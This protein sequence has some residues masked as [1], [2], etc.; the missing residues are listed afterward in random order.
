[1]ISTHDAV[2]YRALPVVC[3]S[4]CAGGAEH[5]RRES[6][7]I[8]G[9]HPV[10]AALPPGTALTQGYYDHILLNSGPDGTVVAIGE[11]TGKPVVVVGPFGKGR[12]VACGLLPGLQGDGE[13]T[14]P[15][16]HEAALLLNA[17]RWCAGAK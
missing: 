11:D 17:V 13:E 10:T 9:T 8:A 3:A 5:V 15:S 14:A 7:K 6:W 1:M 12:Y 4:V 16:T 2:G